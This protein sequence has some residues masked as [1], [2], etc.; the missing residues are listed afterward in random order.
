MR[1][2]KPISQR[3]PI[4][5]T[6]SVLF[7]I[8]RTPSYEEGQWN[9]LKNLFFMIHHLRFLIVSWHQKPKNLYY[10]LEANSHRN[11]T[12]FQKTIDFGNGELIDT[13]SVLIDN[14]IPP[15]SCRLKPAL[16]PKYSI[17]TRYRSIKSSKN[18]YNGRFVH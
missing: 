7:N 15:S 3:K 16:K 13:M 1:K 4:T 11:R 12:N 14:A 6:M 17:F 8:V 10:I 5:D 18:R 9:N 2:R